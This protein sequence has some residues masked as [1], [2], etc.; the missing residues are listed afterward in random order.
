MKK[1]RGFTII[2]VILVL[3]ILSSA[4]GFGLLYYQNSQVRADVNTH[5]S[6]IVSYLRLAQSNAETGRN[7]FNAIHLE[8]DSFTTFIGT[9][10]AENDPQ[11]YLT[12]LPATITI[13]NIN[14]SGAGTDIIFTGP[15]GTTNNSGSFQLISSQIDKTITINIAQIGAIN[16]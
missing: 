16:Y 8:P 1:L 15:D 7:T 6:V 12:E 10:Y 11:N 14:L 9:A 5:A 13:G 4:V 2:E 3:V